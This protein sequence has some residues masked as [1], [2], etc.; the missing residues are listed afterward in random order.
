MSD[1]TVVVNGTDESAQKQDVGAAPEGNIL[2]HIRMLE[3]SK[4]AFEQT[5]T[6]LEEQLK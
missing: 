5:K 3:Q 2:Q 1:G 6:Q 4:A